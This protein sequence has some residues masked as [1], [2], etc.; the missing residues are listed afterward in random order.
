MAESKSITFD[1]LLRKRLEALQKRFRTNWKA[2]RLLAKIV[3][4]LNEEKKQM[5][6]DKT[7]NLEVTKE[8]F[9]RI[10]KVWSY[11][12]LR[13]KVE[14][15]VK[16][17]I[18]QELHQFYSYVDKVKVP[19]VFS[20]ELEPYKLSIAEFFRGGI[21]S[22]A[23]DKGISNRSFNKFLAELVS[24]QEMV[25]KETLLLEQKEL[26]FQ[27][28][29]KLEPACGRGE[30]FKKMVYDSIYII[31]TTGGKY[32][33][34]KVA[35][36]IDALTDMSR[37]AI[38]GYLNPKPHKMMDKNKK[39]S[40]SEKDGVSTDVKPEVRI[41]STVDLRDNRSRIFKEVAKGVSFIV[42]NR[43]KIL[44]TIRPVDDSEKDILSIDKIK[45]LETT[46]NL[47]IQQLEA[48]V[49]I[50]RNL[51]IQQLEALADILRNGVSLPELLGI[52]H[53]R[54]KKQKLRK[55]SRPK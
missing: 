51:S 28:W 37:D 36:D 39:I 8:V 34:W 10:M 44:F 17:K 47:S 1:E 53:K 20:S 30:A 25:N 5:E 18:G 15:T 35:E 50:S 52:C 6:F 43:E 41:I 9:D 49:E 13:Y 11:E 32:F 26:D 3:Q 4:I 31:I 16:D 21:L 40:S 2:L 14:P 27:I 33:E 29:Q 45:K 38:I 42:R 12:I 46:R 7:G 22:T 48:L 19:V 54:V 55:N 24:V 23:E